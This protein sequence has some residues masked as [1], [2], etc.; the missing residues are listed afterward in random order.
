[1][2]LASGVRSIA[3]SLGCIEQDTMKDKSHSAKYLILIGPRTARRALL[4]NR[5]YRYLSEVIDDHDGVMVDALLRCSRTCEVPSA[6]R[7]DGVVPAAQLAVASV[8]CFEL[9]ESPTASRTLE[10]ADSS[11]A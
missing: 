4:F 5:E 11:S 3:F 1:M 7:L 2:V 9:V 10:T 8:R 6:L